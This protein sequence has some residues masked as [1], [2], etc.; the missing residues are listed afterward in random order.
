M[1][2]NSLL[3]ACCQRDRCLMPELGFWE[4][5][6]FGAGKDLG[7][8]LALAGAGPRPSSSGGGMQIEACLAGCASPNSR[9]PVQWLGPGLPQPLMSLSAFATFTAFVSFASLFA[10]SMPLASFVAAFV[11]F[12]SLPT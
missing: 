4:R 3:A 6:L 10:A 5:A 9:S 11:A 2:P 8:L 12:A 7:L 1:L